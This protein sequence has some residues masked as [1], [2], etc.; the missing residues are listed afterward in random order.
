M[1]DPL[2]ELLKQQKQQDVLEYLN[3]LSQDGIRISV[4]GHFFPLEQLAKVMTFS[5]GICYMPDYLRN[6][7]GNLT[8]I[9]FDRVFLT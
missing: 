6:D 4:E 1:T 5:E 9:R 3:N 7:R 2:E 8:E